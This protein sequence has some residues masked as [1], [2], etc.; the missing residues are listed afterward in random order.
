MNALTDDGESVPEVRRW[1]NPYPLH[2]WVSVVLRNLTQ[3]P[4]AHHAGLAEF[5][6]TGATIDPT[7]DVEIRI[8]FLG[9]A[10]PVGRRTFSIDRTLSE[11]L[12]DCDAVVV[13]FEGVLWSGH[14]DPP[15]VTAAQRHHDLRVLEALADVV[16]R[17]RLL[18][19]MANNHAA[20]FGL[21]QYLGTCAAITDAGFR[22]IGTAAT[23]GVRVGEH[24]HVAA[25]TRWTNQRHDY[26]PMIGRGADPF[27]T[28]LV[29][30]EAKC[31][32]L[33]PHWGYEH[34]LYPRP[35]VIEMA[36]GLL[37]HWDGLVAH[38]PHVPQPV[39]S[40][41]HDGRPRLVAWSLGQAS[42]K[43]KWPIYRH[44]LLLVAGWG[45]RPDGRWGAGDI[46]WTFVKIE[47]PD[48]ATVRLA[49]RERCRWFP[50]QS[51]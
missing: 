11:A 51:G 4:T 34:E 29:D 16:P 6:P 19:S 28:A 38:H 40:V 27:A 1:T 15:K 9:D 26:L 41:D 43:I 50:G 17:E 18:V 8:G 33:V 2:E 23:P 36:H 47:Q 39:S 22:V 37:D 45:P 44:G 12:A 31:N 46:D 21:D 32:V 14:G 13:N 25:A 20:D 35:V 3:R 24:V 42:S 48:D 10:M 5:I 49:A 30:E 7:V